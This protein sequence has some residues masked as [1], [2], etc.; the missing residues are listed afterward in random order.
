MNKIRFLFLPLLMLLLVGCTSSS[1]VDDFRGLNQ[2]EANLIVSRYDIYWNYEEVYSNDI[3]EGLIIDQS[4]EPGTPLNS[5]DAIVFTISKGVN[6]DLYTMPDFTGEVYGEVYGFAVGK[7]INIVMNGVYSEDVERNLIIDQ[8]IDSGSIIDSEVELIITYSKGLDPDGT[9]SLPDFSNMTM[10]D[11]REWIDSED[12]KQFDLYYVFSDAVESG[13]FVSV[14]VVKSTDEIRRGDSFVFNFSAGPVVSESLNLNNTQNIKGV[15]LGGWFVLEGWMT[16]ELFN[17]VSGSD[18]TIFMEEKANAIEVIEQHWDTFITYEDFVYLKDQG[19]NTLRIPIPWW[20]QGDSF[21]Y[22]HDNITHNITYGDSQFY[23][24]R[25]MQWAEELGMN[26]L[27]DLHTAP[28]G[29]NGFDNG[30]ITDVLQWERSENVVLTLQK[31]EQ[32]VND[33]KSYD[34]LWGIELL[35]EPGWGVDMDI[36]QEY[37]LDGYQIIREAGLTDVY[38]VFHDGFR[39]YLINEWTGFFKNNDLYN[40]LFDLHLYQTFG[41]TWEGM[42]I[43]DHVTF[44]HN[45]QQQNINNYSGVVPIIIGEWSLGLQGN[46]YEGYNPQSYNDI[47]QAYLNA[48]LNVFDT[49]FGWFFWNYKIDSSSYLEWDYVRLTEIELM[50]DFNE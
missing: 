35:N 44:V 23:I 33:F 6:P 14:D 11:V 38:V 8:S 7:D 25:A 16:P 13:S 34:S 32:I 40:V 18:E 17:G 1:A 36:L 41:D 27:L 19:I 9:I 26:V 31:I 39:S 43:E 49:A 21:T 2:E 37:Y 29:Q 47:R 50:P 3:A 28:G 45:Q 5:I 30:G 22:T 48:Q 20:Y 15:N 24:E 46:V 42:D 10:V 12:I 4:V